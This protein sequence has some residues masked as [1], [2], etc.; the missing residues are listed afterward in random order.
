[1]TTRKI[2]IPKPD[3]LNVPPTDFREYTTLIMGAKGVGKT[4]AASTFPGNLSF[5][6]EPRRKNVS[7]RMIGAKEGILFR[8]AQE[9]MDGAEDPWQL[10]KEYHA[11]AHDDDTVRT[12]TWD[13]V[14]IAYAACQESICAGKGVRSG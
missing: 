10:F 11:A 2:L 6:W 1:M 4:T 12:V 8:P 13:S 5:M 14:D 3:D 7:L 9:I